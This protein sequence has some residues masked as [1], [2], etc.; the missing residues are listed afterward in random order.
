MNRSAL[1][2]TAGF[3][4]LE[5]AVAAMLL[6]L[7]FTIML[8]VWSS[9]SHHMTTYRRSAALESE[10]Q[11]IALAITSEIRRSQSVLSLTDNAIAFV[12]HRDDTV[13]YSFD[14]SGL[15]KNGRQMTITARTGRVT[16]CSFTK[17]IPGAVVEAPHI[18]LVVELELADDFDNTFGMR[19][20]VTAGEPLSEGDDRIRG[21]NF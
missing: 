11:R 7:L 2:R 10:G 21:W 19:T 9:L 13:T 1:H 5:L 16:R 8:S 3:T 15:Y 14:G 18:L 4:L 12:S 20:Q 17:D 6:G